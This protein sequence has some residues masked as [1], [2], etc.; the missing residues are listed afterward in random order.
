[1][2]LAGVVNPGEG[3]AILEK[4]AALKPEKGMVSPYMN[5]HYVEALLMCK[6]KETAI[7]ETLESVSKR[8]C[9]EDFNYGKIKCKNRIYAGCR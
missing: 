2:V 4:V 5:H 8:T 1:M 7:E 9:K 3:A 6:K